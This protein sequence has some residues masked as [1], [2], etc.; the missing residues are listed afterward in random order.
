MPIYETRQDPLDLN[1]LY[2][3][4]NIVNCSP[5][6]T[7]TNFGTPGIDSTG[8]K[9]TGTAQKDM[10]AHLTHVPT[11]QVTQMLVAGDWM[12]AFAAKKPFESIAPVI[13]ETG[14]S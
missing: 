12:F 6:P 10:Y 9:D 13:F 1:S 7:E 3:S 11:N 8:E 5:E 2:R 14:A 4:R